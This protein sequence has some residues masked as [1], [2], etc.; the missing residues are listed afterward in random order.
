MS[1]PWVNISNSLEQILP[2]SGKKIKRLQSRSVL[3]DINSVLSELQNGYN[4]HP[5]EIVKICLKENRNMCHLSWSSR[6][7]GWDFYVLEKVVVV[8]VPSQMVFFET[9]M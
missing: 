7:D 1:F 8:Y 2:R 9:I 5:I 3:Y 4:F 6:G